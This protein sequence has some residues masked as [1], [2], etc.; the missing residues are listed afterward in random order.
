[1]ASGI[2][3]GSDMIFEKRLGFS[4]TTS[5]LLPTGMTCDFEPGSEA[6]IVRTLTNPS[7]ISTMDLQGDWDSQFILRVVAS[8]KPRFHALIDVGALVTG[9]TNQEVAAYLLEHGLEGMQG[10]VYFDDV[11]RHMVLMR[12][13]SEGI[14]L[15]QCGIDPSERFTF[16]NQTNATGTDC[17]QVMDARAAVTLGKD[18]TLRELAQGSWRMRGL[19][20]GQ[21]L[22]VLVVP[23]VSR[24]VRR[25]VRTNTKSAP[26]NESAAGASDAGVTSVLPPAVAELFRGVST[27]GDSPSTSS[28]AD[29]TAPQDIVTWLLA[30]S[31]RSEQLQHM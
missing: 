16:F 20:V 15:D 12:G 26:G 29:R 28:N 30:A 7:V 2:D 6:K 18:M 13:T 8:A 19:G 24:L 17:P 3:M 21:T 9:M 14:Q 23:E 5:D 11:G 27:D 1:M 10:V 4:G 25:A 22:T 31:I